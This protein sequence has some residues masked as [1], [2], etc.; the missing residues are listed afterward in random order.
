[1]VGVRDEMWGGLPFPTGIRVWRGGRLS[2][3]K[4]IFFSLGMACFGEF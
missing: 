3:Q 2:P 1:L 4:K